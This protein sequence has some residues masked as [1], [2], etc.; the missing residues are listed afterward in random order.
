MM[1]KTTMVNLRIALTEKLKALREMI[2]CGQDM[3]GQ[4]K[5]L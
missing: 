4:C 3:Y 2:T 5:A 1:M